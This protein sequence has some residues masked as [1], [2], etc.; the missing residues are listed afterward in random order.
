MVK[1]D[2]SIWN[3]LSGIAF[4]QYFVDARWR[5]HTNR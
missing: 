2:V 1:Y 5:K 4:K 3:E